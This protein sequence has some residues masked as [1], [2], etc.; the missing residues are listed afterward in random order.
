MEW[1]LHAA[2]QPGQGS[3]RRERAVIPVWD[4]GMGGEYLAALAL[5]QTIPGQAPGWV[6]YSPG[7]FG[8]QLLVDREEKMLQEWWR[9]I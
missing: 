5:F 9:I 7:K 8:Y 4:G 1:L 3:G 2:M 6:A